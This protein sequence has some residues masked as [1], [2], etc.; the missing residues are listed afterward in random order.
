[1]D[2]SVAQQIVAA[3][4]RDLPGRAGLGDEWEQVD[5][6]VI[7]G[8]TE[9]WTEIVMRCAAGGGGRP[10][11]GVAPVTPCDDCP[12]LNNDT[13]QG[14]SCNLGYSSG[15]YWMAG[16]K[17]VSAAPDCGLVAISTQTRV[18]HRPAAVMAQRERTD[19][20]RL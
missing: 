6:Q 20:P 8:I 1:M 5:A 3:I 18:I 16:G 13:E 7:A 10:R 14:A 12:C 4:I 2:R 15:L 17:S 9:A 19:G 11:I